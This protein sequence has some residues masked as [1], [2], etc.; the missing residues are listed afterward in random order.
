MKQTLRH[1][2][3]DGEISK[4]L[5]IILIYAFIYSLIELTFIDFLLSSRY[6]TR[7]WGYINETMNMTE[8]IAFYTLKIII[9][10]CVSV[11]I[12]SVT[13]YNFR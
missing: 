11:C 1:T 10:I 5:F 12:K 2:D 7:H 13:K 4:Q 8:N 3:I 9:I 6:S